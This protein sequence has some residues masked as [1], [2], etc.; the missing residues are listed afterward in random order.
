[1]KLWFFTH[2]SQL[3]VGSDDFDIRV[4]KNEEILAEMTETDAVTALCPMLGTRFGYSLSNGTVGVYDK[5]SR[6]WRIKVSL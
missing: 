6:W 3:V 2:I 4:F 1:M 5:V